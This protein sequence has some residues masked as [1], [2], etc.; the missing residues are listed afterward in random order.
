MPHGRR[1]CTRK[2]LPMHQTCQALTAGIVYL[3]NCL[4][5]YCNI[6]ALLPDCC[7]IWRKCRPDGLPFLSST[8]SAILRQSLSGS[9]WQVRK[10]R[11]G[12]CRRRQHCTAW[13]ALRMRATSL[14]PAATSRLVRTPPRRF[15]RTPS[16]KHSHACVQ[17]R[18]WLLARYAP[19]CMHSCVASLTRPWVRRL[20]FP[21]RLPRG[22]LRGRPGH[23]PRRARRRRAG[24]RARPPARPR[25]ACQ[26]SARICHSFT[27]C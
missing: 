17:A 9:G 25:G 3:P 26:C 27:A 4:L 1:S 2:S 10:T 24:E 20:H 13:P 7:V 19:S 16:C 18:A 11:R 12:L 6:C 21:L 22:R 15:T 14:L 5:S 23:P 8:R